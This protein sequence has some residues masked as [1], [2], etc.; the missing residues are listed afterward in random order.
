MLHTKRPCCTLFLVLCV[1]MAYVASPLFLKFHCVAQKKHVVHRRLLLVTS[2]LC[3]SSLLPQQSAVAE[4]SDPNIFWNAAGT[5]SFSKLMAYEQSMR[6]S[7][8]NSIEA[9]NNYVAVI[10]DICR[11]WYTLARL[12]ASVDNGGVQAPVLRTSVD[13]LLTESA[14]GLEE[15]L[16]AADTLIAL[17][18]SMPHLRDQRLLAVEALESIATLRDGILEGQ[19]QQ[20]VMDRLNLASTAIATFLRD[21]PRKALL[22]AEDLVEKERSALDAEDILHREG[23]PSFFPWQSINAY[24]SQFHPGSSEL[25]RDMAR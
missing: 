5:P 7:T 3:T 15:N 19:R 20:R 6:N 18:D 12:M 16:N 14:S 23:Q 9:R 22:D 2:S 25:L 1:H 21:V 13:S 8:A 10:A 11:S 24:P 4:T 17:S